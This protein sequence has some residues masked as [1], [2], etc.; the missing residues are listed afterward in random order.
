[1]E[2][3]SVDVHAGGSSPYGAVE[4]QAAAEGEA[5][6]DASLCGTAFEAPNPRDPVVP[7]PA[8]GDICPIAGLERLQVGELA[9]DEQLPVDHDGAAAWGKAPGLGVLPHAQGAQGES[10]GE[11]GRS[12][13][14]HRQVSFR[15]ASPSTL[16][17]ISVRPRFTRL[18]GRA[19]RGIHGRAKALTR[20]RFSS[21]HILL[22]AGFRWGQR[23]PLRI[24]ARRLTDPR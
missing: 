4:R 21:S 18:D 3:P 17:G 14:P 7:V 22:H 8:V 23:R 5:G 11:H 2:F 10:H 19:P 16:G 15:V 1:M 6:Q 24:I 12:C 13:S 20:F 9:S